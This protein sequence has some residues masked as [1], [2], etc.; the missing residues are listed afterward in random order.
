M[1][2]AS[3]A[4]KFF[5]PIVKKVCPNWVNNPI[6]R[7]QNNSLKFGVTQLNATNGINIIN[8]TSG[9]YSIITYISSVNE[10]FFTVT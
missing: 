9:K 10:S 8:E 3:D 7:I 5:N 6:P 1:V 2:E 4:R